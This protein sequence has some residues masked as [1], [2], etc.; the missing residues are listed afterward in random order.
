[1]NHDKQDRMAKALRENLLKRK[2]QQRG[3]AATENTP[4]V[5]V[6]IVGPES[7]T[8]KTHSSKT[9]STEAHSTKT[10]PTDGKSAPKSPHVDANAPMVASHVDI[11][12]K[13]GGAT[14]D[15]DQHGQ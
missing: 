10:K 12:L 9:H 1:M 5:A 13:T 14:K 4:R 3:R 15:E 11:D 7:S 8:S 6:D 2:G